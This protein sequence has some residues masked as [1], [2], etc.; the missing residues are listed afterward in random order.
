MKLNWR[1]QQQNNKDR[2]MQIKSQRIPSLKSLPITSGLRSKSFV[3]V[4]SRVAPHVISDTFAAFFFQSLL[5]DI[6]EKAY[7]GTE[8]ARSTSIVIWGVTLDPSGNKDA[9]ASVVLMKWL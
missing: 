2:L 1:Q 5:P 4:S 9:R 7:D 6:L 3:Y 8:G